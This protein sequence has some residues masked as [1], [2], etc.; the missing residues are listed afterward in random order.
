MSVIVCDARATSL[1]GLMGFDG[2]VRGFC[3]VLFD[4]R[5]TNLILNWIPDPMPWWVLGELTGIRLVKLS[6]KR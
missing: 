3:S 5:S 6:A 2:N 1:S 4:N